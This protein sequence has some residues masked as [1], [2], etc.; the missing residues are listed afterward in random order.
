AIKFT[1]EGMVNVKVV[2]KEHNYAQNRI[3]LAMIVQDSGIGIDASNHK[4][5]FE[6]FEQKELD[7][8]PELQGTGLGLSINKKMAKFLKGD[9]SLSSKLGEGSVFTFTLN[10]VEVILSSGED[11]DNIDINFSLVKPEGAKI[12]VIDDSSSCATILDA[13]VNTKTEVFACKN[14]SEAIGLLKKQKFDLIFI[15]VNILSVDENAVSKVI[16]KMSKAPVVSL[17]S[18]SIKDIEFVKDGVEIVGHLKKP[19]SNIELFKVSLKVLNSSQLTHSTAEKKLQTQNEF[20][21][22]DKQNIENFLHQ[23]SKVL[24]P[25]FTKAIATN[26]LNSIAVFAK[27]LLPIAQKYKISFL[28]KF[29]QELLEK[30]ELFEIETITTMMQEYKVKIKRL[31]NL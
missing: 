19:I 23:H 29:S 16:A 7:I 17:T 12:M 6:I 13:F 22:L 11:E 25:L 18:T 14:F 15:D 1:K 21:G 31:Q 27:T 9:I 3:N 8:K 30:I 2:V 24:L 26:D 28:A 5:I 10:G 20:R 4:K